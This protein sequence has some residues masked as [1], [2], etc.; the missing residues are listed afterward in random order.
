M[1]RVAGIFELDGYILQTRLEDVDGNTQDFR[2][3][4]AYL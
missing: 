3:R 2:E 4:S 1:G